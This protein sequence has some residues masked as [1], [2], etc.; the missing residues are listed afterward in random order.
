M[1]VRVNFHFDQTYLHLLF[2]RNWQY[3]K[4]D[5]VE[6]GWLPFIGKPNLQVA[7]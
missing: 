3:K 6:Q 2:I 4:L 7:A 1:F 5:S